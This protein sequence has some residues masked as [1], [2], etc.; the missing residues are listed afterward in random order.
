VRALRDILVAKGHEVI[1]LSVTGDPSKEPRG[2][3][4]DLVTRFGAIIA[5]QS[6]SVAKWT[7][8]DMSIR[9][10]RTIQDSPPDVVLVEFS[11]LAF[12]V[13]RIPRG[14]PLVVDAHNIESDL[15]REYGQ[16]GG[17]V[18]RRIAA[19]FD[20]RALLRAERA[21][22]ARASALSFVSS[23]DL[24]RARELGIAVDKN[25]VVSPN[26]FSSDI[27]GAPLYSRSERGGVVFVGN[28]GWAPNVDAAVWLVEKVWPLVRNAV[29]GAKL[30]LVGRQPH[31]RVWAL[32]YS[33]VSVFP[34]VESVAGF[35]ERAAVATAP[36]LA[37]GG[38][39][40][41][42]VEALALGTAV[43]STRL[44][45]L[46][47]EELE[48]EAL[49]LE[50]SP[51][52]FAQRVVELLEHPVDPEEARLLV[53]SRTWEQTLTPLCEIVYG[54]AHANQP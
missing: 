37:A 27:L 25:V 15:V 45:A 4:R 52:G 11:Q 13:K 7:T 49:K 2:M 30:S 17:S 14:I 23:H 50:D 9:I 54:V 38:T 20:W 44:G 21:L 35:I 43:V 36:L 16:T 40:L 5:Y 46:G 18:F 47:L 12:L 1:V 32:E 22:G 3:V 39:R 26:G 24:R 33:D 42:I 41:K 29:P 19:K 34:D 8:S 31:P 51:Q 6:L 10:S 28:L 48:G 53:G